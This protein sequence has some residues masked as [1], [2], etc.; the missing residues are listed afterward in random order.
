MAAISCGVPSARKRA[1]IEHG[2]AVGEMEDDAHVVLDQHDGQVAVLVQPADELGDLVG[3][4]VAHAGGR[5]VEQQQARL[6]RERHRDLGGALVAVRQ[7]ADQPVG[8]AGKPGQRQHLLDAP[9]QF[10]ARRR[11]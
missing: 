5:L 7:F 3:L 2:D 10:R 9:A 8:L 4:L 1:L 11:G 6:E